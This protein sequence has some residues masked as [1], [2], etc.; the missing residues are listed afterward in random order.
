ML[1]FCPWLHG[2]ERKT[3]ELLLCMEDRVERVI[4]CEEMM[5]SWVVCQAHVSPK[6]PATHPTFSFLFLHPHLLLPLPLLND[7]H[8]S[9]LENSL[10]YWGR[11]ITLSRD[12]LLLSLCFNLWDTPRTRD[13]LSFALVSYE[14]SLSQGQGN[15]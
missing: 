1:S 6:T 8:E 15:T 11:G 2:R 12:G 3:S 9:F 5:H 14:H 7:K 13:S 10:F 4:R